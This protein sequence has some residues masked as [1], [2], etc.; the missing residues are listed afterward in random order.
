MERRIPQ[1]IAYIIAVSCLLFGVGSYDILHFPQDTRSL[2]LH[3]TASA[4]DRSL[5]RNNPASLSLATKKIAYSY[6]I[7][8]AGIR[9]GEIQRVQKKGSGIYAGKLSYISYGDIVDGETQEKNT[10]IDIL[11]GMGYKKELGNIASVGIS[12][13]YLVSSIAGYHSQLLYASIGI[14]SRLIRKRMGIGLSFE[15]IGLLITSYTDVK[16]SIP[17]IFRSALYYK[18]KYLPAIISVDIIRSLYSDAT[19]LSGGLEFNPGKRLIIR[20]GCSNRRIGFLTGDFLSDLLASMS[21]GL[22]FQFAKMNLDVGFMNLG[23]AG[24]IIG[25]SISRKED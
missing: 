15:N 4:Y 10:A 19:E 7:L 11:L 8:P 25:F 14:R 22:G 18:P 12:G 5:L 21:G 23:A 2:S 6:L 20:L 9:S 24:Y 16:E 1:L 17:S 3:N 13:G